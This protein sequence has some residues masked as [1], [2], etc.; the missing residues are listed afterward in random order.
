MATEFEVADCHIA[1]GGDIMNTVPKSGVTAAEIAVLQAIH[2][3]DAVH[4]VKITGTIER[5]QRVERERLKTT[6]GNARDNAGVAH[7]ERLY[8]G[9]AA[10]VFEDF[11]ELGL[12]DAQYAVERVN[13]GSAQRQADALA[14][15]DAGAELA[16]QPDAEKPKA[17]KGRKAKAKVVEAPVEDT[18]DAEDE[19]AGVDELPGD[20]AASTL[21]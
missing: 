15:A 12:D 1:L 16:L 3:S 4:E 8:P 21:E 18:N 13:R 17:K 7:V 20:D 2:G 5:S 14:D 10:R 11:D 9:A 6:Y 19:A